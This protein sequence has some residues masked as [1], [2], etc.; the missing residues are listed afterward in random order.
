MINERRDKRAVFPNI[1]ECAMWSGA[2]S[3]T[4]RG[5]TYGAKSTGSVV[6][7][8]LPVALAP[9]Y[10]SHVSGDRYTTCENLA[11]RMHITYI[12]RDAS[13]QGCEA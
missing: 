8:K 5:S 12:H 11:T 1:R 13:K 4:A 2:A 7:S 6:I 9:P 10:H 3:I